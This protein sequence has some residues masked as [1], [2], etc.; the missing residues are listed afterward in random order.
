MVLTPYET[1]RRPQN[2]VTLLRFSRLLAPRPGKALGALD[3]QPD[4]DCVMPTPAAKASGEPSPDAGA[5]RR[6]SWSLHLR[7]GAV[8]EVQSAADVG[9]RHS[10]SHNRRLA[11]AWATS[12]AAVTCLSGCPPRLSQAQSLK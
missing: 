7:Q 9:R 6:S 12:I 10:C 4:R 1:W 5:A 2:P 11:S 8:P 3:R